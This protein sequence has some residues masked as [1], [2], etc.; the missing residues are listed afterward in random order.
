MGDGVKRHHLGAVL[1]C[2]VD[3][4][5]RF[6]AC[7]AAAPASE[8]CGPSSPAD[9]AKLMW[10]CGNRQMSGRPHV[11]QSSSMGSFGANKSWIA[12]INN[13]FSLGMAGWAEVRVN[14]VRFN[15]SHAA[16]CPRSVSRRR[17]QKTDSAKRAIDATRGYGQNDRGQARIV[18]HRQPRQP[19][20]HEKPHSAT[21]GQPSANSHPVR[22]RISATACAV[23]SAM[24]QVIRAAQ[25]SRSWRGRR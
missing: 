1:C 18:A 16:R 13:I 3:I 17:R 14:G 10:P 12:S 23:A 22:A 19:S 25:R 11:C 6:E 20:A 4:A 2:E 24:P 15:A 21:A 9:Q 8:G 7:S 5:F